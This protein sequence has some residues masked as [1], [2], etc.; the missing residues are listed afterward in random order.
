MK[1]KKANTKGQNTF[2]QIL[3]KT[4]MCPGNTGKVTIAKINKFKCMYVRFM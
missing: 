3:L 4:K 2:M 1:R